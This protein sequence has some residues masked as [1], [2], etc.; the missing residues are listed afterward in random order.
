M[1]VI[2]LNI[3]IKLNSN[4]L[5]GIENKNLRLSNFEFLSIDFFLN[6]HTVQLLKIQQPRDSLNL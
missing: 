2:I 3:K 1:V 4:H 6:N 5:M